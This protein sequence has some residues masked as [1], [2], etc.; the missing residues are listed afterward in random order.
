[1]EKKEFEKAIT[2]AVELFIGNFDRFEPNPQLRVN[3]ATL[4]VEPMS[5]TDFYSEIE[6]ADEAVENAAHAG[7]MADETAM[8]FQVTENPDF[9]PMKNF[10][11]TVEGKVVP[12]PLA[13]ANLASKYFSK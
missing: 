3:P 13:I 7:G 11:K 6:D 8:D 5:G 1:M 4:Y 12:N 9:Y 2:N 10:V